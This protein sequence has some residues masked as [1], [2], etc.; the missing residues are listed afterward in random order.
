MNLLCVNLQPA[1]SINVAVCGEFDFVAFLFIAETFFVGNFAG[2][3]NQEIVA[4]RGNVLELFTFD[5]NGKAIVICSTPAFALV[6]S[7]ITFRL[8]G[9]SKDY[10][11]IGSDAGKISILEFDTTQKNWKMVHCEVFGRTGC[12]RAVPGQYLAA[13]PKGRALLIGQSCSNFLTPLFCF[14]ISNLRFSRF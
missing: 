14:R 12:R 2:T 8:A 9:S 3:K 6:R 11:V 7:L 13:D 4:A 5:E 1:S 10:L